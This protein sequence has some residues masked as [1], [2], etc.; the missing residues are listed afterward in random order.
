MSLEFLD[1]N[2][3]L[4]AYDSGAGERHQR[5]ADLVLDLARSHRAA[6]SVQ[7]MQEFYVNAV[8]KIAEP[9]T[10]EQAVERLEASSRWRVHAPLPGD[11]VAAARLAR[12]ARLSFWDAMIVRSA[13][14]F[15]CAILWTEDLNA[16]QTIQGVTIRNPFA[17]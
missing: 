9:M 1:T 8:T 14:Q 16:G 5:A 12:Q 7:V 10:P 2:F 6:I 3:L 17:S 15:K 4:Y 13:I 11:A